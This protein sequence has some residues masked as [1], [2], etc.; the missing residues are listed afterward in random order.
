MKLLLDVGGHTGETVRGVLDPAYGFERIIT[1]EPA[2]QCWAEL[3]SIDDPRV[4]LC[5]FGLWRENCDAPLYDP[6]SD[7]ASIFNDFEAEAHTS[8]VATIELV[9]ASDWFAENV[10]DDDLVFMKLNCEGAEVDVIEDLLETGEFR[11]VYNA[12]ITF[13]VRKSRSLRSRELPLRRRLS[14]EGYDNVAYA[15]DVLRGETHEDRIR[16]WLDMVGARDNLPPAE[17]RAK[18]RSVLADL[19]HRSGRLARLEVI[20][21]VHLFNY[22][23]EPLK[24]LVRRIW[25]RLM[26]GRRQGPE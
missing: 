8:E 20:L 26:R 5:R 18:Y 24:N 13:D 4:E 10:A 6:G 2:P 12:M 17:L 11:K 23:P 1:F 21:R 19:S 9:R 15:E 7:A 22:M 25:G 16:H 14:D 3:E